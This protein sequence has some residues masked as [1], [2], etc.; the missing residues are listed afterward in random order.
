[1][2]FSFFE[3]FGLTSFTSAPSPAESIY[4]DL[5]NYNGG[6]EG[7]FREGGFA[8]ADA[9]ATA[10]QLASIYVDSLRAIEQENPDFVTVLLDLMEEQ[11]GIAKN[12]SL[13]LDERRLLLKTRMQRIPKLQNTQL[14]TYLR[15]GVTI[16]NIISIS[17]PKLAGYPTT[18]PSTSR[19][20]E[21][22]NPTPSYVR[23]LHGVGIGTNSV[24]VEVVC[25]ELPQKNFRYNFVDETG[26]YNE[27]VVVTSVSTISAANKQYTITATFT[28]P[29][30]VG[31][32]CTTMATPYWA[33]GNRR[34]RV[35]MTATAAM[36]A[37]TVSSVRD[38]LERVLPSPTVFEFV[39]T[40]QDTTFVLDSDMLNFDQL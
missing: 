9:A 2:P 4:Q 34:V 40:P 16:G 18:T 8:A 20:A 39:R 28:Q 26:T 24:Q 37:T 17:F 13:S 1:M 38:K 6:E 33:T 29:H 10:I 22:P 7:L 5:R 21:S 23:L 15:L 3:G 14:L 32:C 25:G 19:F 31:T 27:S 35:A 11:A 36:S 12:P 30:D